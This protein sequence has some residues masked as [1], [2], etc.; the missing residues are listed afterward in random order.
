[1]KT[2]LI[3]TDE[4]CGIAWKERSGEGFKVIEPEPYT[5]L[6]I[7]IKRARLETDDEY[8]ARQKIEVLRHDAL[9]EKERLEYLRLKVKYEK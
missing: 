8:S 5:E 7:K 4:F 6:V 2:H 1:M 9:E 3:D